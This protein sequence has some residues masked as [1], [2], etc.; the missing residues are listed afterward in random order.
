[1]K[2][3]SEATRAECRL[4]RPVRLLP[5]PEDGGRVETGPVQFGDDWPGIFI[6]GD[7][8]A[9]YAMTLRSVLETGGTVLERGMLESLYDGLRGCIAGPAQEMFPDLQPNAK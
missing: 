6:R 2:T 3:R 5:S 4:D 7:N 1:M 8:A 9:Y